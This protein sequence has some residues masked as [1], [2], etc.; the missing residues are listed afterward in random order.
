MVP[1]Q[2]DGEAGTRRP[3]TCAVRGRP[4][5]SDCGCLSVFGLRAEFPLVGMAGGWNDRTS[6]A[7]CSDGGLRSIS[8]TYDS[9]NAPVPFI[10]DVLIN[11]I[12]M[13]RQIIPHQLLSTR[14][15][16]EVG[17]ERYGSCLSN[18]T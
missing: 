14:P 1:R 11:V 10:K 2:D 18:N 4:A 9:T 3:K 15:C 7:S 16:L 5:Q 13:L 12:Y 8:L 17:Q 6:L